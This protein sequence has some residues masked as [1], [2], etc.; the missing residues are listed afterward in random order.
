MMV[1]MAVR[2]HDQADAGR[3]Y[4]FFLNERQQVAGPAAMAGVHDHNPFRPHDEDAVAVV[5]AALDEVDG[6]AVYGSN[7]HG[8]AAGKNA[9]LKIEQSTVEPLILNLQSLI[10]SP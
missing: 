6:T 8:I 2:V 3:V 10:F 7:F 5:P 9:R 1:P 4:V